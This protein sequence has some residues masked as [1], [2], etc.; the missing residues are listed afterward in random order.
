MKDLGFYFKQRNKED[1][2]ANTSIGPQTNLKEEADYNV[3][4]EIDYRKNQI[5]N[6]LMH[7][8]Q[9]PKNEILIENLKNELKI[10]KIYPLQKKIKK[11][12][13]FFSRWRK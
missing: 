1:E 11:R 2:N 4:Y 10:L 5:E 13:Y 8:E 7:I 6:Y 9:N 12:H 3:E